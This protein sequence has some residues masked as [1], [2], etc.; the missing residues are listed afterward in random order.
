MRY[1]A[2]VTLLSGAVSVSFADCRLNR[3]IR[4]AGDSILKKHLVLHKLVLESEPQFTRPQNYK[5][6][7]DT[8]SLHLFNIQYDN[9]NSGYLGAKIGVVGK[10]E[11]VGFSFNYM[12]N[13]GVN[14]STVTLSDVTTYSTRNVFKPIGAHHMKG[15]AI[16]EVFV[17][18]EKGDITAIQLTHPIFKVWK[19]TPTADYLAFTGKNQK[20]CVLEAEVQ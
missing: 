7:T 3:P 16:T 18:V 1:L 10:L 8:L 5:P 20:V 17:Q 14:G 12:G 6:E 4:G 15:D 13:F 11:S 9:K 19:S 2:L